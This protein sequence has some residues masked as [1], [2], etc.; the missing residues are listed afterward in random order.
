MT[1]EVSYV[2]TE[3]VPKIQ[4]SAP[5][6][7]WIKENLSSL[8][9]MQLHSL[10]Q[11][12]QENDTLIISPTGSGKTFAAFMG[13]LNEL[14]E[15]SLELRLENRIYA[16]YVSP[17]K[18]L[19]N[20]IEKNLNYPVGEIYKTLEEKFGV[21]IRQNSRDKDKNSIEKLRIAVRTGDTT[22]YAKQKMLREPPHILITTPESLGVALAT[23]KFKHHL[24][25]IKWLI[26]DEIH[27][28]ADNK[29]G[30]FLS[31]M[32]EWLRYYSKNEFCQIGIS[33][34]VEPVEKIAEFLAGPRSMVSVIKGVIHRS[35]DL[36]VV[37][38]DSDLI[39]QRFDQLEHQLIKF[40]SQ[41]I[42]THKTTI[43]FANT[44][45]WAERLST[46]IQEMLP[47]K[48]KSMIG[49]H[50]GS[51]HRDVRLDVE[52]KLK[53]GELKAVVT[54]T[55]LEL[56]ID[57]GTISLAIQ[58]GSPKSVAKALQRFGRAGHSL[59]ATSKGRFVITHISDLIEAVCIN[60]LALQGK[61]DPID[62][63]EAPFDV[64]AQVIVGLTIE[65]NWDV[66]ELYNLITKAFPYKGLRFEEFYKVITALD[67]PTEESEQWKYGRIWLDKET[68]QLGKR[69]YARTTFMLNIGTIPD[70]TSVEVVLEEQ[71]THLGVL[72]ERFVE[73]LNPND[74]FILGGSPYKFLRTV[75]NKII[76]RKAVGIPPTIPS[77]VGEAISR[78]DLVA[79]EVGYIFSHAIEFLKNGS[80]EEL[81]SWLADQ[82]QINKATTSSLSSFL[83]RQHK[84]S[85]IPTLQ[86]LI[87]EKYVDRN[88]VTHWIVLSLFGRAVNTPL[89]QAIAFGLSKRFSVN[90][91]FTAIDNGF[92][93]ILP[94]GIN[95]SGETIFSLF[96]TEED[97]IDELKH[98]IRN[99]E[100]FKLRFRHVAVR[101][102]LVLKKSTRHELSSEQQSRSAQRLLKFLP[103]NFPLIEETEREI[104]SS[105]YN[106][107]KASE[108]YF[109]AKSGDISVVDK[110]GN[111]TPS[112]LTH[113]IILASNS[114]VVLMQDRR[115]LLL[116]LHKQVIKQ[117]LP[118]RV[119]SGVFDKQLLRDYFSS[120]INDSKLTLYQRIERMILANGLTCTKKNF[121]I[122]LENFANILFSELPDEI[123]S[124]IYTNGD[125][126]FVEPQLRLGYSLKSRELKKLR[127]LLDEPIEPAL[128]KEIYTFNSKLSANQTI[129]SLII[130]ILTFSG[131]ITR[132]ELFKRLQV[133]ST[134]FSRSL[135]YL[136]RN[137]VIYSGA[138]ISEEN[139]LLLRSDRDNLVQ[140]SERTSTIISD[141]D[142]YN[143]KIQKYFKSYDGDV[144]EYVLE[145]SP[146][147]DI[148]Q[149]ISRITN[150]NVEDLIAEIHNNEI[151]LVPFLQGKPWFVHEKD[152]VLGIYTFREFDLKLTD[153]EEFVLET[154][155]RFPGANLK[156]LV[157]ETRIER[158]KLKETLSLL[159]SQLYIG[160][161][162]LNRLLHSLNEEFYYPLPQITDTDEETIKLNQKM[163]LEKIVQWFSPL[164]LDSLIQLSRLQYS[165]IESYLSELLSERRIFEIS[166]LDGSITYYIND[167]DE[168][169]NYLKLETLPSLQL[170]IINES[171]QFFTT[172]SSLFHQK[173]H[174]AQKFLSIF[175]DGTIIGQ[176]DLIPQSINHVQI[177]NIQL[178]QDFLYDQPFITALAKELKRITYLAFQ[179][180]I[181]SIEEI[182]KQAP[183]LEKIQ[184][185][186]QIF[187]RNGF[188]LFVDYLVTKHFRKEV[189]NLQDIIELKLLGR[190][191]GHQTLNDFVNASTSFITADILREFETTPATTIHT[192]NRFVEE[193]ELY[194]LQDTYYNP[195]YWDWNFK[196]KEE[197]L[198]IEEKRV[199]NLLREQGGLTKSS[200]VTQAKISDELLSEILR[201]LSKRRLIY[202]YIPDGKFRSYHSIRQHK[203][204]S[205][206]I[207]E[208]ILAFISMNSLVTMSEI[209]GIFYG[210]VPRPLI[211][212]QISKM[213]ESKELSLLL[214]QEPIKEVFY[215]KNDLISLLEN[216]SRAALLPEILFVDNLSPSFIELLKHTKVYF[217]RMSHL[218]VYRGEIML[219]LKISETNDVIELENL[220]SGTIQSAKQLNAV[221][222]YIEQHYF[223]QG[224]RVLSINQINQFQPRFWEGV[225]T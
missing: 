29:R 89:S 141:V 198:G 48:Y 166:I 93:V 222:E 109:K 88:D 77:W 167:L 82:Y 96:E 208:R 22:T 28:L 179:T 31:L 152:C 116:S 18:A 184:L 34:T 183:N 111:N 32:I 134:L 216:S 98:A 85:D 60:K 203:I 45:N 54:S 161:S 144:N 12:Q 63:P 73:K 128:L 9:E 52:D 146:I 71:R 19:N 165:V 129:E 159:E 69:R 127:N 74:V 90:V 91:G 186:T 70:V 104:L 49:V 42:V 78:T 2:K 68:N 83:E 177:I 153:T 147:R 13:I 150:F 51:L 36:K 15:L 201:T 62:I 176:I 155:Q 175:Y 219:G 120:K 81:R 11:I 185:L 20:D 40:I 214:L 189:I 106:A 197:N 119:T 188:Q 33:A 3:S 10:E 97:L 135:N 121:Q 113:E 133:E 211:L 30:T 39:T 154:I 196:P 190:Y 182:N 23:K 117:L 65:K 220:Q 108:I 115:E 200:L 1:V 92:S 99:S 95:I 218:V 168:F 57:V 61:I 171:D 5:V 132:D 210:S 122:D 138:F 205:E 223:K 26:I 41:S 67:N 55:S 79:N 130:Q 209:V 125:L 105:T 21:K 102:L 193:E 169:N 4:L 53:N 24:F 143:Y 124:K 101:G 118:K 173:I 215:L 191:Q 181:L 148:F 149:L 6:E 50:H 160:K 114:D 145:R 163:F 192:L 14:I 139:Q 44:R 75:G 207:K 156:K 43:V 87:V 126:I 194:F 151:Y 56:G 187:I 72:S 172:V 94:P 178:K 131:P 76:V 204:T 123:K 213:L 110:S 103:D 59:E 17:L 46:K 199:L 195:F 107:P 37:T 136:K 202:S 25:N 221:F 38:P 80:K 170:K 137:F 180:N 7:S 224:F 217:E 27:A 158:T 206:L 47:E 35:F 8:N 164:T 58:W 66:D 225:K 112:P 142:I 100:L 64:L 86:R 84:I 212:L 16:I 174:P 140:K 162:G 157:S